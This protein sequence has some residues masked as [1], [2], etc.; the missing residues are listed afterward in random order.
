[1]NL[2]NN[3]FNIDDMEI[4]RVNKKYLIITLIM[5][6]VIVLLLF[7]KKDNYYSNSFSIIDENIVLLVENDYINKIKELKE[8]TI[9]DIKYEFRINEI[10]SMDNNYLVNIRLDTIVKNIN[11]G[12]YKVYLGKERLFDYIIRII[13]K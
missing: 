9:Q 5:I 8:I 13:K 10:E 1:M 6:I 3:L 2:L 7:I 11:H 4:I 12:T